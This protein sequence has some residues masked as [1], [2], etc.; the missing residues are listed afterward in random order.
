MLRRAFL[1]IVYSFF[2]LHSKL[3]VLAI[4]QTSSFLLQLYG[5]MDIDSK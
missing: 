1:F 5:T 4:F 2:F 3:F